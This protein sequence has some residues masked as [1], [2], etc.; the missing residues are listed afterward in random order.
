M[1]KWARVLL[2]GSNFHVNALTASIVGDIGLIN[3]SIIP[4]NRRKIV[5]T[6]SSGTGIF[7]LTGSYGDAGPGASDINWFPANTNMDL[8]GINFPVGTTSRN[9]FLRKSETFGNPGSDGAANIFFYTSGSA[10][11]LNDDTDYTFAILRRAGVDD[12]T[13]FSHQGNEDLVL[14]LSGSFEEEEAG[15][16]NG[17]GVDSTRPSFVFDVQSQWTNELNLRKTNTGTATFSGPT[18]G[19]LVLGTQLSSSVP[20]GAILTGMEFKFRASVNTSTQSTAWAFINDALI[21][22]LLPGDITLISG[23]KFK[24]VTSAAQTEYTVGGETDLWGI[25]PQPGNTHVRVSDIFFPFA[26]NNVNNSYLI[27]SFVGIS[28]KTLTL[29]GTNSFTAPSLKI[30]YKYAETDFVVKSTDGITFK[31]ILRVNMGNNLFLPLLRSV[32][33]TQ[34]LY[35]NTDSGEITRQVGGSSSPI[36]TKKVKKN[37]TSLPF[38]IVSDFDKLRP[39]SFNFKSSPNKIDLGFIAEEVAEINPLLAKFD[40]NKNPINIDD[41]AIMAFAVAKLQQLEKE[42]NNI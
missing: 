41:R 11:G 7:A 33:T 38:S 28:G 9:I 14:K 15:H 10:G 17:S 8:Q 5:T 19:E 6:D 3:P 13:T 29:V 24:T 37:I 23:I 26:G 42:L 2:S 32:I 25:S 16:T 12:T 27:G 39:V 35:Y 4:E 31:N 18:N 36:S 40:K 21:T 34:T 20:L 22:G 1:G 30:W